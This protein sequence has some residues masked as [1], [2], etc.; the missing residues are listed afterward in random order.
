MASHVI[1]VQDMPAYPNA[2]YVGRRNGRFGLASS[3][4]ANPY[5][6]GPAGDRSEVIEKYRAWL[7]RQLEVEKGYSVI[8]ALL[9]ARGKPLVCW[10]RH[11][12]EPRTDESICHADVIIEILDQF[13]DAELT[14]KAGLTV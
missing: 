12:G 6:I 4:L 13:S 8:R 3:P 9:E 7:L 2:V 10:C 11:A 5:P 1:H 14:A